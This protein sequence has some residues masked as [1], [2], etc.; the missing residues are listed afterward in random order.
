MALH[1]KILIGLGLGI[2]VGALANIAGIGWLAATLVAIEPVGT[3]FIRL[4]TMIVVPLIV[5]SILTGA[6]SLGDLSRLG[7]IGGKTIVFYMMTTAVAVTLGL[8]LS[9]LVIGLAGNANAA[10]LSDPL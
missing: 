7:R 2:A 4:I 9:D 6:A 1:N 8:V 5:A 10:G 3:A